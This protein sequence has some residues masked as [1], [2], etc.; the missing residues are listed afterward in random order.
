MSFPFVSEVIIEQVA[1]T[2]SDS[3][4]HYTDLIAELKT[5]QPV[6]LSYLLSENFKLLTQEERGYLL[7]LALV[8]WQSTQTAQPTALQIETELIES[9]EE[10]N[11]EILNATKA[12]RFRERLDGFFDN[13]PQ[14]DLLAFIEDALMEEEEDNFVTKEGKELLFIGLKTVVDC[15]T[16]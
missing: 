5:S 2:L 10:A 1:N 6:L 16:D 14:E 8:I 3:E 13:T 4:D 12:R 7:Y 15:L 9:K 11:W